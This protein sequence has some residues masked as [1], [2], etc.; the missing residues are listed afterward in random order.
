MSS[1]DISDCVVLQSLDAYNQKVVVE[2]PSNYNRFDV[3]IYFNGKA[4]AFFAGSFY[5]PTG[6]LYGES[7]SGRISIVGNTDIPIRHNVSFVA[8]EGVSIDMEYFN[9][10][11]DGSY[12]LFNATVDNRYADY[13]LRVYING[14]ELAPTTGNVYVI[15]DI[16]ENKE[17]R[18]VLTRKNPTSNQQLSAAS[19]STTAG[20]ITIETATNSSIQIA[21]IS[22]H[23]I[24][25]ANAI[26]TTTVN[27][28]QGIYVVVVDGQS[29]KVVVR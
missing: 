29:T 25:N 5:I 6:I 10:V 24:Y 1:L 20:N 14:R 11:I 7:F 13:D 18:F 23:L 22:G 2:V 9:E 27:M 28:P 16:T 21:S 12:F 17:V 4:Y 15:N 3:D 26:G 8:L 19:I